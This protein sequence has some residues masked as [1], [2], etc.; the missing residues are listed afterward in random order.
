LIAVDYAYPKIVHDAI[1]EREAA[2]R[3]GVKLDKFQLTDKAYM[4]T[5]DEKLASGQFWHLKPEIS[6]YLITSL[7]G[8]AVREH[9]TFKD[10]PQT[11]LP[12]PTKGVKPYTQDPLVAQ[13]E[14]ERE[15]YAIDT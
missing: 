1:K 10:A 12:T 6:A 15:T 8:E 5:E 4:M 13:Q 2:V 7:V 14:Q 11:T 3:T 9:L